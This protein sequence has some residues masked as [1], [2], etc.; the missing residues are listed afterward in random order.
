MLRRRRDA[1]WTPSPATRTARPPARRPRGPCGAAAATAA[2]A[3][4]STPATRRPRRCNAGCSA[5][6]LTGER[7]GRRAGPVRRRAGWGTRGRRCCRRASSRGSRCGPMSGQCQMGTTPGMA[8]DRWLGQ[9]G[10]GEAQER[11]WVAHVE[12]DSDRVGGNGS[13]VPRRELP[14]GRSAVVVESIPH[15]ERHAALRLCHMADS[16]ETTGR[17]WRLVEL[18]LACCDVSGPGDRTDDRDAGVEPVGE[19]GGD[20][21]GPL[22]ER[23]TVQRHDD[24]IDHGGGRGGL[25]ERRCQDRLRRIAGR[26]G[27]GSRIAGPSLRHVRFRALRDRRGCWRCAVTT[28]PPAGAPRRRL[29]PTRRHE[30]AG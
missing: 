10:C 29:P 22:G 25:A 20:R 28:V 19:P 26:G 8:C 18:A 1:G 13:E 9:C 14:V 6:R 16:L 27:A 15:R 23:R 5:W 21:H 2:A 4:N 7:R 30:H 12:R 17:E 3:A 24:C 11:R